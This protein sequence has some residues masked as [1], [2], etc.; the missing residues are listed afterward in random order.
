MGA[1]GGTSAKLL[2][3]AGCRIVAVSDVSCG[4]YK[5][6]GL[7]IP[8]VL[9]YLGQEPGRLLS[10]YEEAGAGRIDNEQL[11]ALD[12]DIL[13]PAALEN[14]LTAK[15]APHVQARIV[16]EA[17]NGPTTSAGDE[18]LEER[19]VT[20]VP[21]ILVNAGGVVVSYFEWVQNIQAM[22]WDLAKVNA[23]L[24]KTMVSAFDAV[25]EDA[26]ANNLPLR[27]S[28]YKIALGRLVAVQKLRGVFP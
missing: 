28:A 7:D 20:V 1:V 10:G 17:A 15:T 24:E 11:L 19:G 6:D 22:A 26:R 2:A 18:I 13:I 5:E 23:G 21:D 4:L 8:A 25:W 12:V 3:Q 16:I 9:A 14:Q 27:M